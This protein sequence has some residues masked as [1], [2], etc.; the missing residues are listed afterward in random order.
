MLSK[1]CKDGTCAITMH[2]KERININ[3]FVE[4]I[5]G[6]EI[7]VVVQNT[8]HNPFCYLKKTFEEF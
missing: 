6:V 7:N 2:L 8:I 5:F 1:G 4:N 3:A